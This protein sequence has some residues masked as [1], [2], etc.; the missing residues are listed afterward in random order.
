MELRKT[1]T[2][3]LLTVLV[4]F[5]L[6]IGRGVQIMPASAS[7]DENSDVIT[8]LWQDSEFDESEYPNDP[9]DNSLYLIQV[10]EGTEGGLFVY[11]Y[12]P[13]AATRR[14]TATSIN[15][16]L[17]EEATGTK[18][19]NLELIS[20]SGVFAKYVVK[21]FKVS[22]AAVRYYNVTSIYRE[23]DKYLDKNTSNDNTVNEVAY[24]V[25]QLWTAR[26]VD[27]ETKYSMLTTE[28]IEITTKYVGYVQYAD[29]ANLGWAVTSE[30]T[31]AHFVAFSTD[32]PIDKLME[33]DVYFVEQTVNAK[34]CGNPVHLHHTYKGWYD[35]QYGKKNEHT[36]PVTVTY[37]DKAS[38]NGGQGNIPGIGN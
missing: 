36:P 11:V 1:I 30:A 8:D 28:T 34:I 25:G 5:L 35:Y 33:A 32:K 27:G 10:A 14:L 3:V 37:K 29:G 24:K 6:C 12:Q 22:S 31:M 20:R 21:N 17:S 19:Y 15:M 26:T 16:S 4:I 7:A 18:L 38:N 13:S 2:T 23:W 9:K